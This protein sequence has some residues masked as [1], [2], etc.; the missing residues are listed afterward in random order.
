MPCPVEEDNKA[1]LIQSLGIDNAFIAQ[2]IKDVGTYPPKS[3]GGPKYEVILEENP[4][5]IQ[6]ERKQSTPLGLAE[7]E[8]TSNNNNMMT[9]Q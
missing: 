5:L 9:M 2:R 7:E 8:P 1:M 6:E 3:P 4:P